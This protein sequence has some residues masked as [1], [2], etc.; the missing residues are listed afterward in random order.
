MS[1]RGSQWVIPPLAVAGAPP[2]AIPKRRGCLRSGASHTAHQHNPAV[3]PFSPLGIIWCVKTPKRLRPVPLQSQFVKPLAGASGTCCSGKGARREPE[4]RGTRGSAEGAVQA[5][6]RVPERVGVRRPGSAEG[7]GVKSPSCTEREVLEM[8]SSGQPQ[9]A[10]PC[11][12][13][14]SPR[15]NRRVHVHT[16]HIHAQT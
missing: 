2:A 16:R 9:Q 8:K 1:P 10:C 5:P 4:H 7:F 6:R 12:R 3:A 13:R 15:T 14:T 11:A